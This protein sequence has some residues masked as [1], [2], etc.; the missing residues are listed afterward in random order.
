[1]SDYG[2]ILVDESTQY[3]IKG[4]YPKHP[5][6][7]TQNILLFSSS[8]DCTPARSIEHQKLCLQLN[9]DYVH[10][11]NIEF[12]EYSLDSNLRSSP[13]ISKLVMSYQKIISN[14]KFLRMANNIHVT[15]SLD[16]Q[17][18]SPT[19]H[20]VD[21]PSD[22]RMKVLE[23]AAERV[24]EMIG[25][26]EVVIFCFTHLELKQKLQA[27][28]QKID[29]GI[30]L[31]FEDS[32]DVLGCQFP[33]ALIVLDLWTISTRPND[34]K[35][36]TDAI[37]RATTTVSCI[38]NETKEPLKIHNT[39]YIQHLSCRPTEVVQC[40][41]AFLPNRGAESSRK[42]VFVVDSRKFVAAQD[43]LSMEQ[44]FN[45]Q[46]TER[47]QEST[48]EKT[49]D[50]SF[51]IELM[52][53]GRRGGCCSRFTFAPYVLLSVG[54]E[55]ET[56]K[57]EKNFKASDERQRKGIVDFFKTTTDATHVGATNVSRCTLA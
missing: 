49:K 20:T 26:S 38:V 34:Q 40:L 25:I 2:I 30:K 56:R 4:L 1:V 16:F 5:P 10:D 41:Q 8:I 47:N 57:W 28:L 48:R 13:P 46:W 35:Q 27:H 52:E 33:A 36:I 3:S 15:T 12:E 18:L 24:K 22:E 55:G 11:Y 42:K 6:P 17:A 44:D 32:D 54:E 23:A 43:R 9:K 7:S 37:T 39:P 45:F 53:S 14:A 21:D 29:F 50:A 19:I 51:V 31:K